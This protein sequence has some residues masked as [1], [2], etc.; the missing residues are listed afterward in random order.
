MM[1]S[2][3]STPC[4]RRPTAD[5][6]PLDRMPPGLRAPSDAI[7]AMPTPLWDGLQDRGLRH[8][9]AHWAAAR[10][11]APVPALSSLYPG[12]FAD[13]LPHLWLFGMEEDGEFRCRLA[14]GAANSAW[15]RMM[16]SRSVRELLGE[17]Y[18][19]LVTLHWRF[20]LRRPAIAHTLTPP[21]KGHSG[22][23]HIVLPVADP[24]GRPRLVLGAT[25]FEAGQAAPRALDVLAEPTFHLL[26][27]HL[28][29]G[30]PRDEG[31]AAHPGE[32]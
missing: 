7:G 25:V 13:R 16:M 29:D 1:A 9:L 4:G 10:R 3:R 6:I 2:H 31:P 20:V 28:L 23:E 18:G 8:L 24:D 27:G 12:R 21:G 32:A 14:G 30:L 22:A 15:G 17:S 5:I 11:D 26:D 19:R